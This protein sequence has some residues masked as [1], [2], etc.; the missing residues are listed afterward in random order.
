VNPFVEEM[1]GSVQAMAQQRAP[2]ATL[3]DGLRNVYIM[4]TARAG[5]LQQPLE[6]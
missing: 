3:T 5:H 4:E 1:A 2:R 6:A